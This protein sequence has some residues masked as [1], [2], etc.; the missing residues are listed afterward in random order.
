MGRSVNYLND[1]QVV[2]F[3]PVNELIGYTEEELEEGFVDW[4][5][6]IECLQESL[7][8]FWESLY[9]VDKWEGNETHIIAENTHAVIALAT[10]CGLA[11]LSIAVH[12]DSESPGLA[13]H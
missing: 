1:A 8:Y 6:E 12:P 11:S 5:T 2:E 4:E 9:A 3:I 13:S 10:Y 7:C